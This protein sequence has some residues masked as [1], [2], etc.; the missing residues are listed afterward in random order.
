MIVGAGAI[1][2]CLARWCHGAGARVVAVD[3]CPR[4]RRAAATLGIRVESKIE[5]CAVDP[6][7]ILVVCT[8]N[9]ACYGVVEAWGGRCCTICLSNGHDARER[10]MSIS[11]GVVEFSAV[12]DERGVGRC[13]YPGSVV[14]EDSGCGAERFVRAVRAGGGRARLVEDIRPVRVAKT[15]LNASFEPVC[16]LTGLNFG[17]VMRDPSARR[18]F[19][20]LLEEGIDVAAASGEPVGSVQGTSPRTL[21]AIL[22]APIVGVIAGAVGGWKARRVEGASLPALREGRPTEVEALCGFIVERAEATGTVA[23]SHRRAIELVRLVERGELRPSRVNA[24][25]LLDPP[26]PGAP[27]QRLA[28]R[29]SSATTRGATPAPPRI[30]RAPATGASGARRSCRI[31]EP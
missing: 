19:C 30:R 4:A 15:L 26:A 24:H 3:V 12:R 8:P 17:G 23:L 5:D 2:Q 11:W 21:H 28:L 31:D 9:G 29:R 13:T 6:D 14:V 22:S 7:S 25:L 10:G 27:P 16:A 20:R 18:C 1:G